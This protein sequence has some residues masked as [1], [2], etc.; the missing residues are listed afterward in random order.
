MTFH[1]WNSSGLLLGYHLL[2]PLMSSGLKFLL[3][4]GALAHGS[5]VTDVCYIA[6]YLSQKIDTW[7]FLQ[8]IIKSFRLVRVPLKSLYMSI[9]HI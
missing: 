5:D 9:I 2:F 7:G 3:V 1:Y 6:E 8:N 4:E